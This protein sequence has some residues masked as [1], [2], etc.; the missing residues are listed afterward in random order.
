MDIA[1][2]WIKVEMIGAVTHHRAMCRDRRSLEIVLGDSLFEFAAPLRSAF[3]HGMGLYWTAIGI[4]QRDIATADEAESGVVE[5]VA[6][7]LIDRHSERTGAH[8]R[9]YN[10][11]V[12]E[13]VNAGYDLIG[14]VLAYGALSGLGIIGCPNARREQ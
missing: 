1:I 4:P 5:V 12:E 8:K 9:V 2:G 6:V 13:H 10:L 11:V 14:V 7:E 3:G